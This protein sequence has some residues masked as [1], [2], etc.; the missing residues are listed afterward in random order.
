MTAEQYLNQAFRLNDQIKDK[1]ER[2]AAL[3][4]LSESVGA[5]DYSKDRIQTSQATDAQFVNH[6]AK[7]SELEDELNQTFLKLCQFQIEVNQAIDAVE[8][9]TSSLFLSKRYILMKT[10]EEIADEMGYSNTHIYK[11][12]KRALKNFKVPEK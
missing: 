9:V 5:I 10:M 6:L 3:K 1:Q 8:D 7:I 12:Q 4:A 2:I 11:V